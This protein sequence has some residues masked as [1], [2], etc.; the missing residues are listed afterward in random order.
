[1]ATGFVQRWKGKVAAQVLYFVGARR[2]LTALAGGAQTGAT[3]LSFGM[4]VVS[5]VAS[6]NDSAALPPAK[7]SGGIVIVKNAAAS[8]SLQ[9][10]GTDPDTINGI[11]TGTGV[12][13]AHD[14][15]CMYIDIESGKW[16]RFLG[17]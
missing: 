6:G 1:M 7:G 11:A 15:T 9:V 5:T 17:A 12:A 3:K 13:Q 8:N 10:F 2:G 4:N 16:S 14:I